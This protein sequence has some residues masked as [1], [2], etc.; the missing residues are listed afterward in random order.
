MSS[1][2]FLYLF[3]LCAFLQCWNN[4]IPP[5]L[6]DSQFCS[7]N[8]FQNSWAWNHWTLL[9]KTSSICFFHSS[10]LLP[11]PHW[12]SMYSFLPLRFA[13]LHFQP[14]SFPNNTSTTWLGIP[15]L[16]LVYITNSIS[17]IVLRVQILHWAIKLKLWST[18]QLKSGTW[19][20]TISYAIR[21]ILIY[22]SKLAWT[23]RYWLIWFA[24][25]LN[26][27]VFMT[28]LKILVIGQD[29]KK[30]DKSLE[31]STGNVIA[32]NFSIPLFLLSLY[33]LFLIFSKKEEWMKDMAIIHYN[34][35]RNW[36][37]NRKYFL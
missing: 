36:F 6:S 19:I 34:R 11:F 32:L 18:N 4:G 3:L 21:L 23:H 17:S 9:V 27:F 8:F 22:G 10:I 37:Q 33:T 25:L 31:F 28:F 26:L 20:S 1:P 16:L 30:V 15:S 5:S 12:P 2:Q 29:T 24:G 13:I 35:R 14:E 7:R